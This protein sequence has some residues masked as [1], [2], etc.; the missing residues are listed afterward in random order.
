[1]M[2]SFPE[3]IIFFCD[4]NTR[5]GSADSLNE[6]GATCPEVIP[7][8][9]GSYYATRDGLILLCEKMMENAFEVMQTPKDLGLFLMQVTRIE[10]LRRQGKAPKDAEEMLKVFLTP[11]SDNE[12]TKYE[13]VTLIEEVAGW[14]GLSREEARRRLR[15]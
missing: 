11:L 8:V 3:R 13:S 10:N 1:M 14:Y 7:F 4:C 15:L 2:E 5:F 9:E 6:H 12:M